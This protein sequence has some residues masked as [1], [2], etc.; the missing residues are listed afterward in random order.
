[1][2]K[3]APISRHF[4]RIL[5]V[6]AVHLAC[7]RDEPARIGVDAVERCERGITNALK[8]P[9]RTKGAQTYYGACK[10]L[11]AEPGCRDAYERASKLDPTAAM[12]EVAEGCRKA[13]CSVL[14][15][16][17]LALCKN[18][19]PLTYEQALKGWGQFHGAVIQH[20]AKPFS[21]RI[22]FS[23]LRFYA[24]WQQPWG[25]APSAASS[26]PSAAPP[27]SGSAALD[28]SAPAGS[29]VPASS[30]SG[31]PVGSVSGAPI[32]SGAPIQ[33]AAP[34]AAPSAAPAK[35]KP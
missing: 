17:S 25:D 23:L 27:A 26:A 29:G 7:S 4:A 21:A 16:D 22:E 14:K 6:F 5:P 20:D 18:T 30:A 12:V 15:Q 11:H 33:S 2:S 35:K 28:A 1:M 31:A 9:T 32:K 13:Y 19:Q 24:R 34:K 3:L 8:A 10:D